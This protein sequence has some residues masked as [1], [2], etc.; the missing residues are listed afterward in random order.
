MKH[1]LE[2]ASRSGQKLWLAVGISLALLLPCVWHP[3]IEAGDVGS[4]LYNAWL[5]QLIERGQAPG[6]YTVRQWDNILVDV[7]LLRL[8][9]V[10]DLKTAE[11]MVVAVS[12]LIFF[13]GMFVF[14]NV[15]TGRAPWFLVPGIAMVTYGWTFQMGFLNYYLSI[16]L[17]FWVIAL[18]WRGETVDWVI[19]LIVTALVLAAHPMG[20]LWLAGTVVYIKLAEKMSGWRRWVLLISAFLTILATHTYIAHVYQTVQPVN[21]GVHFYSGFDQLVLYGRRYRT[22]ALMVVLLTLAIT[23][24]GVIEV[25]NN[26]AFWRQVRTPAELW[27]MTIF[28]TAMLWD[29]IVIPKYATGFTFVASRLTSVT[30]ALGLCVMGSLPPRRW[31]LTAFIICAT[32]FFAMLYQDTGRLNRMEEQAESLVNE[33]PNGTRVIQTIFVPPGSRIHTNHLVDRACIGRCF[34]FSNY[35]PSTGQF[36]IR[37]RPD[38]PLVVASPENSVAMQDGTYVVRPEDLPIAQVYQCDERDPDRLCLRYLAAGE[39]N[40]QGNY[41]PL[42]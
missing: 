29:G 37:A 33:L 42:N 40:G 3:R 22:L 39:I 6:L 16:G 27:M 1:V 18:A 25:R 32:V 19:G 35:E 38:N 30:A 17:A 13:W 26:G 12:V 14:I 15:A 2:Q 20:F 11:K 9:S 8:G 41:H 34:C 21:W 31:H 36:R 10:L 28:A 4:H 23:L 24:A 5:A 7:V